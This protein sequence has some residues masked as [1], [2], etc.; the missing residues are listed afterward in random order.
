MQHFYTSFVYYNFETVIWHNFYNNFAQLCNTLYNTPHKNLHSF[1][2]I[3][4]NTTLHNSTQF[5][6]F[7][8]PLQN[9]AILYNTFSKTSH[10]YTQLFKL[11]TS[12]LY[13]AVQNLQKLH[14]LLHN[15]TQLYRTFTTLHTTIHNSTTLYT[16]FV[17]AKSKRTP[18]FTNNYITLY[19]TIQ[20]L[21][22]LYKTL[23][24]FTAYYNKYKHFTKLFKT[25]QNSTANT[26][27]YNTLH[28]SRTNKSTTLYTLSHNSTTLLNNK[29]K[30][31]QLYT[32]LQ[33]INRTIHN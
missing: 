7:V 29:D 4:P 24:I 20:N 21:T 18:Y 22:K 13:T 25:I 31:T 30:S 2:D 11:Y 9:S 19:T 26:T 17:L 10:N 32:T 1:D 8:P 3:L 12:S 33:N 5:Y 15:F 23:Q 16:T 14:T 28:N 6:T 27:I